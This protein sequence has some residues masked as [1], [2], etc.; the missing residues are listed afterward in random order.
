MADCFVE[1]AESERPTKS[2][3]RN[4]SG[5]LNDQW[6]WSAVQTHVLFLL[7]EDRC[8]DAID[9]FHIKDYYLPSHP[10]SYWSD[11]QYDWSTDWDL[12]THRGTQLLL[13]LSL[14]PVYSLI[15]SQT[16]LLMERITSLSCGED[17][18]YCL[19]CVMPMAYLALTGKG[20]PNACSI[21]NNPLTN[22]VQ[23]PPL[24]TVCCTLRPDNQPFNSQKGLWH[25]LNW[26]ECCTLDFHLVPQ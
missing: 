19:I 1:A 25:A 12:C 22:S 6:S 5:A 16:E 26:P 23:I 24:C 3:S 15:F 21:Q 20:R 18:C 14:L 10:T 4:E 8:S 7:L 2:Q 13:L 9:I 11:D 17:E